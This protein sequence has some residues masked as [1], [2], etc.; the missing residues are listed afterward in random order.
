MRQGI[1]H[2]YIGSVYSKPTLAHRAAN[3]CFPPLVVYEHERPIA[4]IR[5]TEISDSRIP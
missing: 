5:S 1:E 2:I 3:F 4:A